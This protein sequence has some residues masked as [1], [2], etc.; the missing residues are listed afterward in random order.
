MFKKIYAGILCLPAILTVQS[1]YAQS[2]ATSVEEKEGMKI[3]SL[4][5]DKVV[6]QV[7]IQNDMLAGDILKGKEEWLEKYHNAGFGVATDGNFSLKMMWN[8][9]SAPGREVNADVA[10]SFSKRDYQYQSYRFVDRQG[11]G[12]ELDL[13]FTP[14]NRQNTIQ[15]KVTY[16][17]LPDKFYSR[18]QIAVRD[19]TRSG[20][21]LDCFFA[22]EGGVFA[23]NMEDGNN[24]TKVR[25]LGSANYFVVNTGTATG[26][27]DSRI[28]KKGSFGQPCALDFAKGGV[29]FGVEYPAATTEATEANDHQFHV[30]CREIIGAVVKNNWVNSQ[31]IVEGLAPDHY[32]RKWFFNYLPDIKYTSDRPYALYNSWYDLRSPAFKDVAPEHIMNEKNIMTIIRE[33]KKNMIEPY[34]I[35]LDAFVLDDGWDKHH[36]DWELRKSTFPH[37]LKPVSDELKT[38]STTLG[39]WYG[40]TGGYSFR[41]DRIDWMHDHGYEVTGNDMMC[42]AGQK[43]SALFK[44]RTTRMVRQDGVGYFKWDGIQF[45]CSDPSHGHPTGYYSRRAILDSVFSDCEA[46]RA[47]NPDVYLN[48]TSGTWLSPWWLEHANQIWMQGFDYG[49]ADIPSVN[50]RDASMT[51]KDIVLYNDFHNLDDWFPVSNLMTHGIIK[52]ALNEI[53]GADDP[54]NKFTDDAMFYFGRG[55]TMY[56]LYISPDLLNKGE[57]NALSKSLKWAENRFPVLDHTFMTGGNPAKGQAYGYVHYT[58]NKGIIAVRNPEIKKQDIQIKLSASEGMD[59]DVNSL[60]LERVYPT[61]WISP[62]LYSAGAT[63]DLPLEGY[64]SAI[65]EVYPLDSAK[66]PLL[67]GV[68]FEVKSAEGNHTEI[69]VLKAGKEVKLLNPRFV[70][71]VSMDGSNQPLN[72]LSISNRDNEKILDS[73]QLSL[74]GSAINSELDFSK[75]VI[76]PRF[77]VFLHPDSAYQGKPFPEGKLVVDGREVK[78]TRQ[79]QNGV[80][81]DYSFMLPEDKSAGKHTFQF[82][83][84]PNSKV[85]NWSGKADVWLITQ[86]RQDVQSVRIT[87]KESI[88]RIPM[89]PSPFYNHAIKKVMELGNGN[90]SL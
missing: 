31:W 60:V 2:V 12:K 13:F 17:L 28:V 42:I 70:N 77:V 83:I 87:T 3:F 44:E 16:Q 1:I 84:S 65:Y 11:G 90:I 55:V 50:Q 34:G 75:D 56:E 26:K 51:Y 57:W 66:K 15:L 82:I 47:I 21:W 68:T 32:V 58:G 52:G 37:G 69:N 25:G 23:A 71:A 9:W 41:Q 4:S 27:G 49:F 85:T 62:D 22:R 63:I 43:Y 45:S 29:F 30:N 61:H 39:I 79:E 64:E 33:F 59:W 35:H 48:I 86:Q 24:V 54:L 67:A 8:D 5:N 14:F 88:K 89:P 6:Q 80:W 73:K 74:N 76:T 20:N 18:R 36:S 10:I 19:T 7:F 40:P 78:A 46:V 38:L 72:N 53:G 81:S